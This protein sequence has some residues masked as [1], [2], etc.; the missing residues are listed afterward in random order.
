MLIMVAYGARVIAAAPW[1]VAVG[2][3]RPHVDWSSPPEYWEHYPEDEC[4][5]DIAVHK[6]APETVH[7]VSVNVFRGCVP[8]NVFNVS[9]RYVR[10]NRP[11]R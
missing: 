5:N 2:F 7:R 10:W 8:K 9:L 1:F 6:T 4:G 11:R 3:V